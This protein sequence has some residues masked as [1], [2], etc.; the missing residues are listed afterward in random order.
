MILCILLIANFDGRVF[1]ILE[2]V[3]IYLSLILTIVSL[4]D[5]IIKNRKV[6]T[7]GSM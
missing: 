4:I 6:L 1:E 5:Y 2:Q 3:F 7:E